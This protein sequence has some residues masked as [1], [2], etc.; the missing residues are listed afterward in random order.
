MVAATADADIVASLPNLRWRNDH[1]T[2]AAAHAALLRSLAGEF[3]DQQMFEDLEAVLGEHANPTP[4]QAAAIARRFEEATA[5]LVQYVPH[6]VTPY[7]VDEVTCLVILSAEHPRPEYVDGHLRR[8]ALAV[9]TL[10]DLM[11]DA[12]S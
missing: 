12:L 4:R 2:L 1:E 6:L 5:K 7:P 9:L 11:G 3:I 10:I 8:F